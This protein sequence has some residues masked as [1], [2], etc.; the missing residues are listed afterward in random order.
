MTID[1]IETM[2]P[3]VY[4]RRRLALDPDG[5]IA[6]KRDVRS[7]VVGATAADL[8]AA[9]H[10]ALRAPGAMF[11][12][13]RIVRA[14]DR[15]GLPFTVGERFQGRYSLAHALAPT[16]GAA[17]APAIRRA[18]SFVEDRMLSDYAVITRLDLDPRSGAEVSGFSYDYLEGTPIA[19][20]L[21]ME[22]RAEGARACRVTQTTEYQERDLGSLLAFGTQVLRMHNQVFHD[23]IAAAA[24]RLGAAILYTDIPG[25]RTAPPPTKPASERVDP[26]TSAPVIL[27]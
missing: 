12:H 18:L 14:R 16:L 24:A 3:E 23:E 2:S 6:I 15:L 25:V 21:T 8:I 22:C 17:R 20:R 10:A 13:I 11:G 1:D 4:A 26:Q 7:I 19:G 27:G 9:L 5:A